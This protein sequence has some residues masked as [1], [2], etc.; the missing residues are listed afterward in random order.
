MR[1]RIRRQ[2]TVVAGARAARAYAGAAHGSGGASV[3]NASEAASR[4]I[5]VHH[6]G[7][8]RS[9]GATPFRQNCAEL[10]MV[11]ERFLCDAMLGTLARDLRLLGYDATY[12]RP[13]ERDRDILARAIAEGR[14]LVTKDKELARLAG[15]HGALVPARR[16]LDALV[17]ALGLA[18]RDEDFLSLCTHC[19]APLEDAAQLRTAPEGARGGMRCPACGHEYWEGTHVD[20][21]R[22]RLGKYLR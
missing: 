9:R 16:E 1:G 10:S 14:I 20:A 13:N 5:G 22:A 18:P 7:G 6:M 4:R 19:G 15:K 2:D 3:R 8:G 17:D 11:G 12:A 21:I